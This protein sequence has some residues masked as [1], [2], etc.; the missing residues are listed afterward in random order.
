MCIRDSSNSFSENE[1]SEKNKC[2]DAVYDSIDKPEQLLD[3]GNSVKI[4]DDENIVLFIDGLLNCIPDVS[5]RY[6]KIL[7]EMTGYEKWQPAVKNLIKTGTLC[8]L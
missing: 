2:V 1:K 5:E 7:K 4:L 8:R 6:L 3:S